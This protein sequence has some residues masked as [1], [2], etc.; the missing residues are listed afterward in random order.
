MVERSTDYDLPLVRLA[1][2]GAYGWR[3]HHGIEHRLDGLRDHSLQCVASD[4]QTD[5]RH[6]CQ[7]ATSP[8]HCHSNAL[9]AD[10]AKVS[11]HADDAAI[12]LN[13]AAYAAVRHNVY[14]QRTG[15]TCKAP[16]YSIVAHCASTALSEATQN[17]KA[18]ILAE[19]QS[20]DHF[21]N[22]SGV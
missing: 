16:G 13:K 18:S 19:I 17:W 5:T 11:L 4:W 2:V 12:L 21:Q 14:T 15:S 22:L 1:P 10:I 7:L 9:A 6:F 3:K 8:S 20:G